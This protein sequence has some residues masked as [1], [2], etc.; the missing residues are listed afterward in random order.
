MAAIIQAAA[1]RAIPQLMVTHGGR[2]PFFKA[3]GETGFGDETDLTTCIEDRSKEKLICMKSI[4][5]LTSL[6]FE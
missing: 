2:L 5:S 3:E 6:P 1:R 4:I